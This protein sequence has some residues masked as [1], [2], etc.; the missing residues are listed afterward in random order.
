MARVARLSSFFNPTAIFPIGGIPAGS[1]FNRVMCMAYVIKPFDAFVARYPKCD[2]LSYVDDDN[3]LFRGHRADIVGEVTTAAKAF[4]T[5]LRDELAVDVAVDKATLLATCPGIAAALASALGPLAARLS[6]Q[7]VPSLGVD[8]VA[9][10]KAPLKSS[11]RRARLARI[12]SLRAR[13][14]KVRKWM[15]RKKARVNRLYTVALL[16]SVAYGSMANGMSDA[17]LKK[18]RAS[19]LRSRPVYSQVMSTT[20][21]LAIQ[22]DPAWKEAVAPARAWVRLAWHAQTCHREAESGL[23]TLLEMIHW[24]HQMRPE[25]Q[26]S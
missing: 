22:G 21:V 13:Y 17:E 5:V 1:M 11:K 8:L 23:P 9:P 15:S 16:P 20:K 19:M 4:A 14:E 12:R 2:L 10:R 6:T 7:S 26:Q 25:Q 24:Y 18:L 3:L